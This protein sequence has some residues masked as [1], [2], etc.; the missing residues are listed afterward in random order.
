[1]FK[2]L[3]MKKVLMLAPVAAILAACN[4]KSDQGTAILN[5]DTL[6]YA[7]KASYSSDIT[8]PGDPANAQRKCAAGM[9]NVRD[10]RYTGYGNLTSPIR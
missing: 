4:T 2:S 8:V 3:I 10:G 5:K 1:M 9:E 6:V 7:Y